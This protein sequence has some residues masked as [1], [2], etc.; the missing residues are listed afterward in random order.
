[1]PQQLTKLSDKDFKLLKKERMSVLGETGPLS[2]SFGNDVED[3]VKFHVYDMNDAYLKSGISED[4]ENDGNNI[5]LKPGNDL[6]KVGFTRGD[7]KV[8][9]F[10]YR[11]VAG[12]D[13]VVLTKSVG[14]QSGIVH[15][16][17]PQLTGLPMGAFYVDDDGK[18]FE[19][20]KPPVDGSEPSELDV[21]E[22]K[23]FIDEV[24]TD[25]MEV[26]LAPQ[27][28]NLDKYK[29]EFSDLSNEYGIYTSIKGFGNIMSGGGLNGLGKFGGVNSTTF[30]F[31]T[32]AGS[33][34]GFKQKYIGGT[35]EVENAFIVG[36]TEHTN[37]NENDDWE[38]ED[39][40]P[41]ITIET[42][43]PDGNVTTNTPVTFT[44][45]R[46]SGNVAP[47]ELS[48]YW[49]FG[50]GHQEFGG[51]EII[52]DYT[53]DGSMNVSVVINSPNFV[54]TVILDNPL[55]IS[56]PPDDPEL[57]P[58]PS[59]E[60]DRII[61]HIPN[62]TVI[63]YYQNYWLIEGGKKRHIVSWS[64]D[65]KNNQDND[66]PYNAEGEVDNYARSVFLSLLGMKGIDTSGM[67]YN[68][69]DGRTKRDKVTVNVDSRVKTQIL[70][71]PAFRS[72]DLTALGPTWDDES[73]PLGDYDPAYSLNLSAL[74]INDISPGT[75]SQGGISPYSTGTSVDIVAEPFDNYE[76]VNWVGNTDGIVD[77]TDSTTTVIMNDNYTITAHF[78]ESGLSQYTLNVNSGAGGSAGI[79]SAFG[80]SSALLPAGIVP[81]VVAQPNDLYLF[82]GWSGDA[83]GTSTVVSVTMNGNKTVNAGFSYIGG[84][85][86]DSCFIAGTKIL[87]FNG[88]EK[89][90]ENINVGDIITSY[91]GGSFV[92]GTV[93]ELLIH[94][95]YDEVEVAIVDK[96]LIG[97]PSHPIF[98][99]GKWSEIKDSS[100]PFILERMYVDNYYNLEVDG[101]TIHGSEHNYIANG[102]IVSGFG[103]NLVLNKMF[104]RQNI[105]IGNQCV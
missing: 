8:K 6:R 59:P 79:G 24:S 32:K 14:D 25:R 61:E 99:N 46:E 73:E 19:G 53:I 54:D 96:K 81:S 89:N 22:Y 66:D 87:M 39:P 76:F 78:T 98:Y 67:N 12:A 65:G 52:H 26:R 60:P 68:T 10:F 64:P 9:Y 42:D 83:D 5:K 88:T 41:T 31:D 82:S 17:N 4:F 48:Y 33:D 34:P 80:P 47:S 1:M 92:S 105:F 38:L 20:E 37:T 28:I 86:D 103:D 90:I 15:S 85:G 102:C 49:D 101:F 100:I 75:V 74:N 70:D 21:K 56:Y 95:I 2:P 13:E 84:S 45:N 91:E 69:E 40:I 3:F 11:R 57:P 97:T 62:G 16:G 36:Q 27:V 29:E 93:T 51:P 72:D 71:G 7:Y 23:F 30:Q 43:Y 77:I 94:P 50:C 55:S 35:L 104:H 63:H 18:V 58:S 44:A